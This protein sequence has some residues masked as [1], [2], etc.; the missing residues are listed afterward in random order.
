MWRGNRVWVIAASPCTALGLT[1]NPA[2]GSRHS[3]MGFLTAWQAR[4]RSSRKG[5]DSKADSEDYHNNIWPEESN[6]GNRISR[7]YWPR[8]ERSNWRSCGDYPGNS[9][10]TGKRKA[11]P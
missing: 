2:F 4:C 6:H 11:E 7:K 8:R 1:A 5:T 10:P 3:T 9:K